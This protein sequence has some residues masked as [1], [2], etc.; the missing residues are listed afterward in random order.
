MDNFNDGNIAVSG[1]GSNTIL[2]L[3]E[4]ENF[5]KVAMANTNLVFRT[6]PFDEIFQL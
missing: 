2:L 1:S 5:I 4:K 6:S 3:I